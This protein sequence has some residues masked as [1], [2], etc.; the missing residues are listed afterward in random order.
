M[1]PRIGERDHRTLGVL[2]A[3]DAVD[4]QLVRRV[5]DDQFTCRFEWDS[6]ALADR[7]RGQLA[8][9]AET[10]AERIDLMTAGDRHQIGA[11][12]AAGLIGAV[13]RGPPIAG[14]T[15]HC[16]GKY[17]AD[18]TIGDQVF[19]IVDRRRHLALQTDG[20]PHAA[21]LGRVEHAHRLFGVPAERPFAIDVLAGID[22]RHH[23]R[24]MIRHFDADRDQIDI[25][26]RRHLRRIGKRQ[27]CAVTLGGRLG[28]LLPCRAHCDDRELRQGPERRNM[29]NRGKAS[30]GAGSDDADPNLAAGRH[31]FLP[32]RSSRSGSG[33]IRS[34]TAQVNRRRPFGSLRDR[35]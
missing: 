3:D 22:R 34:R 9:F 20:V 18:V 10:V 13:D 23:R 5:L 15:D 21:P 12:G 33:T 1:P 24:V 29:R 28:G 25:G 26:M 4:H 30:A 2:A 14:T 17:L 27:L 11:V 7:E 35:E 32:E 31:Y 6:V 19:D 8:E 16:R